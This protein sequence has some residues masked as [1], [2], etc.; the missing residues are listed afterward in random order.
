MHRLISCCG[1]DLGE[2]T[3]IGF[4]GNQAACT[5]QQRLWR[6]AL[7]ASA[8]WKAVAF[9]GVRSLEGDFDS[10][11][12]QPVERAGTG[13]ITLESRTVPFTSCHA[14]CLGTWS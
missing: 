12:P 2:P 13:R 14:G 1:G 6:S 4:Y 10:F 9:V 3:C 8:R 5:A 7:A 11:R